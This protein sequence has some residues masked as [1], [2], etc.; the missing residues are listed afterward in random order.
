MGTIPHPTSPPHIQRVALSAGVPRHSFLSLVSYFLYAG[1]RVYSVT[2][3]GRDRSPRVSERKTA[4]EC[5]N[6]ISE[7]YF[8]GGHVVLISKIARTGPVERKRW[9]LTK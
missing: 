8:Y 1:W 4:A 9:G 2:T 5:R 3:K 7:A 6:H